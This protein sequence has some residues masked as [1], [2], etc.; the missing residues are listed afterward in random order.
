MNGETAAEVYTAQHQADYERWR[1]AFGACDM[2]D[3]WGEQRNFGGELKV[4]NLCKNFLALEAVA[5]GGGALDEGAA[6]AAAHAMLDT[7]FEG[8]TGQLDGMPVDVREAV[9]LAGTLGHNYLGHNYIGHHYIGP[10]GR[11]ISYGIC[12]YGILVMSY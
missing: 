2:R 4:E 7:M 12:S 1:D 11:H 3:A 6:V 5:P 8:R 10:V 9:R